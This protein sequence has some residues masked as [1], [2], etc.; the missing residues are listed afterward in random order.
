MSDDFPG[1]A[2]ESEDLLSSERRNE[3]RARLSGLRENE[4]FVIAFC[5]L[6]SSG[7]SSLINAVLHEKFKLPMG[8]EPVTSRITR[9]QY[10][11]SFR[12]WYTRGRTPVFL[13]EDQALE[14]IG[15]KRRLPEE[16]GEIVV[17]LPSVLLEQNV[18]ILDTPGYQEREEVDRITHD[19]VSRADLVVFCASGAAFG[20]IFEQEYMEKL[21]DSPGSFCVVVNRM[22]SIH[23]QKDFDELKL[24][25]ENMVKGRGRRVL[26]KL[27]D[28]NIFYTIA[29][30]PYTH[31]DLLDLYL[32]RLCVQD[33]EGRDL[34]RTFA[35]R[36]RAFRKLEEMREEIEESLALGRRRLAREE[37]AAAE[38][39]EE[40][41]ERYRQRAGRI[42]RKLRDIRFE[43]ES[44]LSLRAAG[45]GQK[46][47]E[48]E[49]SG[50]N[51][52]LA[53]E[54]AKELR[55]EFL[56][57]AEY[58]W[59]WQR[60]FRI[61]DRELWDRFL[62]EFMDCVNRYEAPR[63]GMVSHMKKNLVP[64]LQ[65]ILESFLEE[66][67]GRSRPR[68]PE[69]ERDETDRLAACLR[70]WSQLRDDVES[71]RSVMEEN[72]FKS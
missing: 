55:A 10:G 4:K 36:R 23:S 30:G 6:F 59:S 50:K 51:R 54:A 11:P 16:S 71:C 37:A 49:K 33:Q 61:G 18:V 31:L 56:A 7:K 48:L 68:E 29:A 20:K 64:E 24:Y 13:T 21:E 53:Q 17:E 57:E 41:L 72:V 39:Y 14:A 70:Q 62:I 63:S 9:I 60:R 58:F 19:A 27:W 65:S 42:D 67:A 69:K 45:L 28:K 32:Y 35:F 26:G 15:G 2:P 8:I 44:H 47:S 38:K 25:V 3:I 5:G 66:V 40:E 46:L 22:D 12:A 43:W 52:D 1:R 34:L